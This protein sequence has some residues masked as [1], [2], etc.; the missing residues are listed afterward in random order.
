MKV[1]T[2]LIVLFLLPAG[3]FYLLFV[4]VPA[5][6]SFYFSVFDW[7]GFGKDMQFIG[8]QNYTWILQDGYFW[9]SVGNTFMILLLGGALIFLLA[10]VLM[11]LINSGVKGKKF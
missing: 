11:V 2:R 3:L 9:M 1:R 4:I 10:F 5:V 8:L 7:S 6:W